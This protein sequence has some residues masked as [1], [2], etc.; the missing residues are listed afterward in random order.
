M[1]FALDIGTRKI[2][3]LL[4]DGNEE[5]KMIVHDAILAV[6]TESRVIVAASCLRS[7]R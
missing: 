7:G 4:V 3:G 6:T 2:A 5:G 1:L